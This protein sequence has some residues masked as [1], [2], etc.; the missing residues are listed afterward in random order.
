MNKTHVSFGLGVAALLGSALLAQDPPARP[1]GKP[2]EAQSPEKQSPEKTAK[3]D[4]RT[5]EA[6][7]FLAQWL[8]IENENE[9]ELSRIAVSRAQSPEVKQFAQKMVDDHT[10]FVQKLKQLD[11]GNADHGVSRGDQTGTERSGEKAGQGNTGNDTKAAEASSRIGGQFD[12][13]G[14]IR[15]LGRKCRE[16]HT[17]ILNEKQGAEFDRCFMV[18]ATGAHVHAVDTLEVFKNHASPA[19]RPTLEEGLRTVQAHLQQA[20]DLCKKAEMEKKAG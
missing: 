14:L 17:K 9:V 19:L 2:P 4:Q 1:T 6:D 10:A 7:Y 18:M 13:M 16:S 3:N 20:K 11:K 12:H 15:D 5:T 8:I